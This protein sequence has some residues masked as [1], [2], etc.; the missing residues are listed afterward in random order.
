[1]VDIAILLFSPIQ[2]IPNEILAE[3]MKHCLPEDNKKISFI[4]ACSIAF[5]LAAVCSHWR[6]VAISTQQL[7]TKIQWVGSSHDC[8]LMNLTLSRSNNCDLQLHDDL[9]PSSDDMDSLLEAI[10]PYHDRLSYV[11]DGYGQ[12][13]SAIATSVSLQRITRLDLI[14]CT[15]ASTLV[16]VFENCPALED[17]SIGIQNRYDG[18]GP[19]PLAYRGVTMGQLHRLHITFHSKL[20]PFIDHITAPKLKHCSIQHFSVAPCEESLIRFLTRSKAPLRVLHLDHD[21]NIRPQEMLQLIDAAPYLSEIYIHENLGLIFEYLEVREERPIILPRLKTLRICSDGNE[22]T[23]ICL[24]R[25]IESRFQEFPI[26]VINFIFRE[27][28]GLPNFKEGPFARLW[29]DQARFGYKMKCRVEHGE[30][31]DIEDILVTDT[32]L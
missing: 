4:P 12:L 23:P 17:A 11:Y 31:I 19:S 5:V 9:P 24:H 27:D 22:V 25:I 32:N 16:R 1:M 26:E 10:R 29:E 20:D 2:H 6:M 18:I 14:M 28:E 15:A 8:A 13:T 21:G 30:V 7:W 3:I